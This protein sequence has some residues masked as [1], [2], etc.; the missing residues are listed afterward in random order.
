MKV[1]IDARLWAETGV[2]RYIRNLVE[3]LQSLD[4]KNEY[5]LF[6]Q[7]SDY[8]QVKKQITRKN[9]KIVKA[10]FRWHSLAEQIKYPAVLYKEKLD[11]MHFPY[12]SLP[13]LYLKPFVVTIH[14]L[15]I[16]HF[17]TGKASTL[18]YP[19]YLL[20][21]AGYEIV[22]HQAVR[23]AKK[24][25]APLQVTREDIKL[26]LKVNKN[27]II[28]TQE[29]F[30]QKISD[31]EV[32]ANL[33]KKISDSKY[34]MYVGNAYPHKNV[35]TLI[36]GFNEFKQTI[37]DKNV[38]LL[39]VGKD[40]YF[41]K[42]LK[43]DSTNDTIIFLNGVNDIDLYWLYQNA[44]AFVS[45]SSMEGF[46]LPP[47]E[48]MGSTCLVCVSDIPSFKEVCGRAAIYFNPKETSDIAK[49]MHQ[50][51]TMNGNIKKHYIKEGEKRLE[52][53]SWVAM[54][55]KTLHVYESCI[56]V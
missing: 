47:L 51:Y 44:L 33:I 2:G 23:R 29:G 48:A 21:R 28:V 52:N 50:I 24:I 53:F 1:G 35:N 16:H 8:T 4:K 26:S 12:Y 25:I 19:L 32:S 49:K 17:S 46:G 14:D 45:A 3:E 15:I 38:K 9:W 18:P 5:V 6:I 56:S 55:E 20:K 30:D 42:K 31:G 54:A 39:L 13:I 36:S 22:L 37:G 41:Y 7:S 34:F 10:D 27:K 11:L 40:D 43:T